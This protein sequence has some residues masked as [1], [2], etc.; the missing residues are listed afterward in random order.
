MVSENE[1]LSG[2]TCTRTKRGGEPGITTQLEALPPIKTQKI[3]GKY[4]CGVE[5]GTPFKD[6]PR[7]AP[8]AKA[9]PSGTE[10][11]P[12]EASENPETMTCYPKAEHADK[13]PITDIMFKRSD[14]PWP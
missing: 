8:G 14:E 4:L 11:C 13:C 6:I 2:S 10:A 9:C 7:P 3:D 5:G 12:G 1:I